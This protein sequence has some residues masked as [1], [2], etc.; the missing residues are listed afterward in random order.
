MKR[1]FKGIRNDLNLTIDEMAARLGLTSNEYR[2]VE[3][4]RTVTPA[5]VYVDMCKIAGLTYEEL[6]IPKSKS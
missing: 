2:G 6:E 3:S 1:S 4:G 5:S